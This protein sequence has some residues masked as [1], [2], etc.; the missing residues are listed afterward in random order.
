MLAALAFA[1]RVTSRTYSSE[2][3]TSSV[4]RG[5]LLESM[6]HPAERL[7]LPQPS[8]QLHRQW[9]IL[10]IKSTRQGQRW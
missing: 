4:M 10:L 2:V 6:T 9:Q 8:D 7:F 1:L 3:W 5:H